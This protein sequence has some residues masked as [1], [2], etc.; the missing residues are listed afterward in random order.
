MS[1]DQA[2]VLAGIYIGSIFDKSVSLNDIKINYNLL[3]FC[4]NPSPQRHALSGWDD[5]KTLTSPLDPVFTTPPTIQP[6]IPESG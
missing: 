3:S 5:D 1:V 2:Q 4:N 6:V